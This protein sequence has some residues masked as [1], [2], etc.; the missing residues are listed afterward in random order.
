MNNLQ[1]F[2]NEEF[3]EIRTLLIDGQPWFVGKDIVCSLGY[4]L[5]N[6]SYTKYIKRYCDEDDIINYNKET[7]SHCGLELDYKEFG[8]RGGLLINEYALYDL[9][10]ESPL[11]SAKTFKSWVTHEVLPS[12]R[13][14]GSYTMPQDQYQELFGQFNKIQNKI[15][16]NNRYM[17]N[18]ISDMNNQ[19]N[20]VNNTLNKTDA[21]INYDLKNDI[22]DLQSGFN[23]LTD[24]YNS[25]C[26]SMYNNEDVN[27]HMINKFNE[28][29]EILPRNDYL[30]TRIYTINDIIEEARSCGKNIDIDNILFTLQIHGLVS[31]DTMTG[32]YKITDSNCIVSIYPILIF[33]DFNSYIK[34]KN[35]FLGKPKNVLI[36]TNEED[37]YI[38]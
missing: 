15:E 28:F 24:C 33:K 1:I 18:K 4:D 36:Y 9:V 10:F 2:S 11:P 35:I 17:F 13:K 38:Y 12:I 30:H 20:E 6:H 22:K 27:I 26:N 16:S 31:K 21:K 14:T 3:G 32:Y 7:Q 34:V 5:N 37:K 19:I 8:Q 23:R 25:L 29:S